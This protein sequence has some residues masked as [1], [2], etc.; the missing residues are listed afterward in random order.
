[1]ELSEVLQST[2]RTAVGL[3]NR[4]SSLWQRSESVVSERSV[5]V[6]TE[7]VKEKLCTGVLACERLLIGS[8]IREQGRLIGVVGLLLTHFDAIVD[9]EFAR[10]G[11][12]EARFLVAMADVGAEILE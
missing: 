11:A 10:G 6:L 8:R 12:I 4:A 7:V 3:C 1:M 9:A 5:A 2:G